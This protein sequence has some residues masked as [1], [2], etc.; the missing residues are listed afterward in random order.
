MCLNLDLSFYWVLLDFNS[1]LAQLAWDYK[2][3]LLL[4]LEV[5]ELK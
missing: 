1:S 2:T 3:L 5:K 4:L